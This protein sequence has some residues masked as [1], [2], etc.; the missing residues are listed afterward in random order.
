MTLPSRVRSTWPGE[1]TSNLQVTSL[2]LVYLFTS[3]VLCAINQVYRRG[4]LQLLPGEETVII[5]SLA[6]YD[7]VQDYT[8]DCLDT[9]AC[10]AQIFD[11]D[12]ES[13]VTAYSVSTV[14]I[15]YQLS[16]SGNGVIPSSENANGFQETFTAWS[17]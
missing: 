15:T 7:L 2:Y 5:P 9:N 13:S 14:G 11:I 6:A 17:K 10:Q 3:S 12:S 8:Q 1:C 4:L 16:V